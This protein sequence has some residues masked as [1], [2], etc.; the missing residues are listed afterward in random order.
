MIRGG[1]EGI[2]EEGEE[3]I[4]EGRGGGVRCSQWGHKEEPVALL[5]NHSPC[6]HLKHLCEVSISG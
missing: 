1:E 5:G 2:E 3:G 4:E 6:L